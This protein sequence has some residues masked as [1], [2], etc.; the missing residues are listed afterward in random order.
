MDTSAGPGHRLALRV[1]AQ[2]VLTSAS[3]RAG[4]TS[5]SESMNGELS[6]LRSE[7]DRMQAVDMRKDIRISELI[8]ELDATKCR[9]EALEGK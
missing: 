3:K 9:V 5:E 6:N 2:L 4:S 7:L 8:K 1:L